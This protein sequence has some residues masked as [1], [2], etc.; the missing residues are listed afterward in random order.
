MH[1]RT[2]VRSLQACSLVRC[3]AASPRSRLP[4][5]PQSRRVRRLSL[6]A[7]DGDHNDRIVLAVE[8]LVPRAA[9]LIGAGQQSPPP[10]RVLAAVTHFSFDRAVQCRHAA[11]LRAFI[12]DLLDD[13]SVSTSTSAG[14]AEAVAG[15]FVVG[16]LNT[17][18]DFEAPMELL[19]GVRVPVRHRSW[20]CSV[21]ERCRWWNR[22]IDRRSA[23]THQQTGG[24]H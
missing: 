11:E 10:V 23:W 20:R 8:L 7:E 9:P 1:C 6:R 3:A 22:Q 4:L 24:L 17:Y 16:D 12:A 21:T 13:A 15:G 2:C 5:A 19:L 18:A 14:A